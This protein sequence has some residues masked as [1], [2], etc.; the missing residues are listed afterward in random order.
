MN[1]RSTV[2]PTAE[3]LRPGTVKD[4]VP[5]T[6]SAVRCCGAFEVSKVSCSPRRSCSLDRPGLT[7]LT[8]LVGLRQSTDS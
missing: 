5:A 6:G 3:L 2:E 4:F 7:G 8:G 1:W